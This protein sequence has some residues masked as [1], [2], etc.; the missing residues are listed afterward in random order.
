[1]RKHF[2]DRGAVLEIASGSGEHALHAALAFPGLVWRPSDPEPEARTSIAAWRAAHGPGNL[3]PPLDLD[4]ASPSRWPEGPFDAV[5]AI[6]LIHISPWAAT[7]GLMAGAASRLRAGG[8]VFLYGPFIE[9]DVE[10][11]ASNLAFDLDLR[12]RNTAWGL[13]R[14]AAVK[15]LAEQRGLVLAA[16]HALPANNLAVLFRRRGG[17]P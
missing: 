16:R 1:M 9:E 14:L 12:T 5:V 4:A 3:L 15:A 10:T 6:N 8:L 2:P 7:E 13:R 11:A 17:E